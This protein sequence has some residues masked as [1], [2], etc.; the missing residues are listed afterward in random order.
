MSRKYLV[1]ADI[2]GQ[3][4]ILSMRSNGSQKGIEE[5]CRRMAGELFAN[6]KVGDLWVEPWPVDD[7]TPQPYSDTVAATKVQHTIPITAG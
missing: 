4:R 2:D 3:I 1:L 6:H 7:P 5:L